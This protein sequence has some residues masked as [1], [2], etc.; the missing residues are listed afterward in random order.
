MRR[1]CKIKAYK[2]SY[3]ELHRVFERTAWNHHVGGYETARPVHE[4]W[5]GKK[6][7]LRIVGERRLRRQLIEWFGKAGCDLFMPAKLTH[8]LANVYGEKPP[9]AVLTIGLE[10]D[11][12]FF[13]YEMRRGREKRR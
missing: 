5:Y 11:E 9:E 8:R 2:V 3:Y 4:G 12:D 1:T 10:G 13:G 6:W 7:S